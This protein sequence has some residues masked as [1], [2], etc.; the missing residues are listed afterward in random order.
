MLNYT[1]TELI[2]ELSEG[3]KRVVFREVGSGEK[4]ADL[5]TLNQQIVPATELTTLLR[6]LGRMETTL[7]TRIFAWDVVKGGWMSFYM[8]TVDDFGE[9]NTQSNIDQTQEEFGYDMDEADMNIYPS[10]GL[11]R[12]RRRR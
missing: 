5:I 6:M 9:V 11:D 8:Q 7:E 10:L 1:K 2:Q 12:L 3:L 4:S